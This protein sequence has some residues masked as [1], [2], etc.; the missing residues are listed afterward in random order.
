[1][2]IQR[3][4]PLISVPMPGDEH[5]HQQGEGDDEERDGQ[6]AQVAE[7]EPARDEEPGETDPRPDQLLEALPAGS[8]LLKYERTLEAE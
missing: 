5:G 6:V 4:D 3:R 1:M 7:V 8:A 2:T